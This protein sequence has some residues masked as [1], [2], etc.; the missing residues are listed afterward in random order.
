MDRREA[1][2]MLAG[3]AAIALAGC[4]PAYYGA[5]PPRPVRPAWYYDY[6][7]YPHTEVY[8]RVYTG[9]YYYL[10]GGTWRRSRVLPPQYVLDPRF[11]VLLRIQDDRPYVHRAEHMRRYPPPPQ[12]RADRNRDR[13]ERQHNLRLYEDYQKR[14]RP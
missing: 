8:F 9:Y 3:G 11:R 14:R 10:V 5:P 7:Y 4:G 2:R 6:Y 1:I 13:E 12:Y